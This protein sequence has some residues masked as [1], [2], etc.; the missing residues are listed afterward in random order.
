MAVDSTDSDSLRVLLVDGLP[1]EQYSFASAFG[2][3]ATCVA[4]LD[5][6]HT[7]LRGTET[8]DVA[9]VA[10]RLKSPAATGLSALVALREYRPTI[11]I[12]SYGD[13]G[14]GGQTLFAAAARHWF[15]S[16][17]LLDKGEADIETLRAYAQAVARGSDPTSDEWRNKLRHAR[18]IDAL[19]ARPDWLKYWRAFDETGV[20]INL[21]AEVLGITIGQVRTFK[22]KGARAAASFA[23]AFDEVPHPGDTSNYKGILAKFLGQHRSFLLSPDLPQ[24]MVPG[25]P[26]RSRSSE[27]SGLGAPSKSS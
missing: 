10:Y 2:S 3:Q 7:Q 1:A 6:L 11:P 23:A 18:L 15:D 4:D 14:G 5:S 27:F 12:V 21:A 9:F 20:E 17:A 16:F 8:W 19:L 24:L 25:P 13:F 22:E 26:I